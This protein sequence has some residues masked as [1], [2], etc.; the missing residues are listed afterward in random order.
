M[1]DVRRVWLRMTQISHTRDPGMCISRTRW[2]SIK[3]A[4]LRRSL[5]RAWWIGKIAV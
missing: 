3:S 1:N 4:I 5:L 2:L